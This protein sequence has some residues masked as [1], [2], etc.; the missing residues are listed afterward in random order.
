MKVSVG[1][2]RI[3]VIWAALMGLSACDTPVS[4]EAHQAHEAAT[5][6]EERALQDSAILEEQGFQEEEFDRFVRIARDLQIVRQEI[7]LKER[8]DSMATVEEY[9]A[10]TESVMKIV[11]EKVEEG[12]LDYETF[13][14]IDD[15]VAAD[16]VL[17]EVV[18]R[19]ILEL[20]RR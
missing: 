9:Q 5:Q 3:V 10:F 19:R 11:L 12:G 18:K 1:L 15:R 16:P 2:R 6:S 17:Q 4:L 8:L 13:M 14:S 20:G 7:G